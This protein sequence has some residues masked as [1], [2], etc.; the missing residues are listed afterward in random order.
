MGGFNLTTSTHENDQDADSEYDAAGD[1][2][3][4]GSDDKMSE[5][6]LQICNTSALMSI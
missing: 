6:A 2:C 1:D 3:H 4:G 5:H